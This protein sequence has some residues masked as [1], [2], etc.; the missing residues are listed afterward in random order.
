[1]FILLNALVASLDGLIIGI[2]LK[3]S[4]TKLTFTNKLIILLTNV[5]IYTIIITLY[6]SLKV[7]FMT[8]GITTLFYLFLAWNAYKAQEEDVFEQ[9][10]SIKKTIF[11]AAAH[12]LDGSIVSLNF[13]YNYNFLFIITLFSLASILLL[14]CGYS[15]AN[16]LSNI[17]KSNLINAFLFLALAIINLFL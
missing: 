10:L 12:S 9:K 17:K 2:G 8:T 1:M 11:I 6:Y 14:L 16:L 5:F 3:L 13:V 4:K 7:K 15:F